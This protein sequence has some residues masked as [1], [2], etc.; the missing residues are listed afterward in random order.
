M[1]R[2]RLYE[3]MDV[4]RHQGHH[5]QLHRLCTVT[6]A[7]GELGLRSSHV[8]VLALYA[9]TGGAL[10]N[11][12]PLISGLPEAGRWVFV[13]TIALSPAQVPWLPGLLTFPML[14]PAPS[15]P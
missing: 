6:R 9:P 3:Y 5:V 14:W 7:L 1:V 11:A 10:P 8:P 12:K 15:Q 4:E 2:N 13:V